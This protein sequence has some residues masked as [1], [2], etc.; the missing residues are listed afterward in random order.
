MAPWNKKN[1][2]LFNELLFPYKFGSWDINEIMLGVIQEWVYE[3][4]NS[5]KE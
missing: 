4:K 2:T 5:S 1:T 3:E